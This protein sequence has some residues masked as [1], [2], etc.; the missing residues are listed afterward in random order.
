M[1]P[2]SLLLGL[3]KLVTQLE[4]CELVLNFCKIPDEHSEKEFMYYNLCVVA[5]LYMHEFTENK[6][7]EVSFFYKTEALNSNS[8]YWMPVE[9]SGFHS[10]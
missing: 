1:P 8:K 9:P 2:T 6:G 10:N 3:T 7:K 5:C 4:S